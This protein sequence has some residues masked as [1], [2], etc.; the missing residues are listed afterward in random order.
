MILILIV[1][2]LIGIATIL[3]FRDVA[4]GLVIV[5]A[6]AGILIK[7]LSSDGFAGQYPEIYAIV[8]VCMILL[9]ISIANVLLNRK[10][11]RQI[12]A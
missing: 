11:A 3:K 12:K 4:Y 10:K 8:I 5:W 1:G 9:L 7:H 6:Y 2:M